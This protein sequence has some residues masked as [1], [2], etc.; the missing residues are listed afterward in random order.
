M[1]NQIL[2]ENYYLPGQLESAW[3]SSSITTT[4]GATTRASTTCRPPMSSSVG[5]KS[6]SHGGKTSS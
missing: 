6:F 1:K 3:P 4:C 5:A 2:L